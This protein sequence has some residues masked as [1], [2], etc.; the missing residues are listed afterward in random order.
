MAEVWGMLAKAL[1]DNQTIDE[2]IAEAIAS[3]EADSSAH[4][5]TGESL[6][7]HKTSEVI[8]HLKGS[9]V[10]DKKTM[11]EIQFSTNFESIAKW[12]VSGGVSNIG[13]PG[14]R[15]T[16]EDN[17]NEDSKMLTTANDFFIPLDP[18]KNA[19]FGVLA[20]LGESVDVDAFFGISYT[21]APNIDAG[22]GFYLTGN[23]WYG[24]SKLQTTVQTVNLGARV[25]GQVQN[26]RIDYDA[27]TQNVYFYIDGV[28]KGT[29]SESGAEDVWDCQPRIRLNKA[30][31]DFQDMYIYQLDLSVEI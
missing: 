13:M 14:V 28:L 2:A 10:A 30:N 24:K 25:N 11:K 23:V 15:L 20:K 26:F 7:A 12:T 29:I 17:V 22:F 8:D 19:T 9:V 27:E 16:V 3:H 4:L 21:D 18:A 6:E 31:S 5:G 1:D